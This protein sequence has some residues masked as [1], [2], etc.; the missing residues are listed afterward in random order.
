MVLIVVLMI[1][2]NDGVDGGD[3]GVNSGVDCG[4]D[5]GDDRWC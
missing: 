2:G 1:D 4:V 3:D 5:S